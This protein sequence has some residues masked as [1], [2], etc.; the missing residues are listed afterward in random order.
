MSNDTKPTPPNPD[1]K[2]P[3]P[4]TEQEEA[5]LDEELKDSFPASDPPSSGHTNSH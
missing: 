2:K 4:P 3:H 1:K 5:N